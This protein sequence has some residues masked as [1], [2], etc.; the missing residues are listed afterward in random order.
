MSIKLFHLLRVVPARSDVDLISAGGL[1]VCSPWLGGVGSRAVG[2]L[3]PNCAELERHEQVGALFGL[4]VPSNPQLIGS[5]ARYY[6][7]GSRASPFERLLLPGQIDP[8]QA[9][10]VL[11]VTVV[12]LRAA[13][14]Q[15]GPNWDYSPVLRALEHADLAVRSAAFDCV[16]TAFGLSDARAEALAARH[17]PGAG[18]VARLQRQIGAAEELALEDGLCIG[19]V[20]CENPSPAFFAE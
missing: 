16:A 11:R 19:L 9:A 17:C 5:A 1:S 3:E 20:R 15:L 10:A 18:S 8:A 12:L 2:D 7:S 14:G 4:L 6:H 13:P